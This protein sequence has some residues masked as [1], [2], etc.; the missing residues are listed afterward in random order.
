MHLIDKLPVEVQDRILQERASGRTWEQIEQL[1]EKFAGRRLPHTSLHRWYDVKFEQVVGEEL[2]SQKAREAVLNAWAE[3]DYKDLPA[4]LRN[5]LADKIADLSLLAGPENA[6]KFEKTLVSIGWLLARYRQL[7]QEQDRL[8]LEREK[9]E[10]MQQAGKQV[11]DDI[12]KAAKKGAQVDLTA[13]A[14]KVRE[15]YEG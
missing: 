11:A 10:R 9:L 13:L 12:E 5:K 7:D 8:G 14:Q 3:R 4:S 2:R 15:I 6:E 1:S